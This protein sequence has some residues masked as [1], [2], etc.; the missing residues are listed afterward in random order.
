MFLWISSALILRMSV[1]VLYIQQSK[2]IIQ[3]KRQQ[4]LI[5]QSSFP[6]PLCYNSQPPHTHITFLP[7][8]LLII[9]IF[10]SYSPPVHC[11]EPPSS[12]SISSPLTHPIS[13]DKQ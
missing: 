5:H 2:T 11:P 10:F 3:N 1:I 12:S 9:Q 4:S 8:S 7:H 13:P 6:L